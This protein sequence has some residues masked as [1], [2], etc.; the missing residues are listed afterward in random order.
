MLI[1]N[2]VLCALAV[3]TCAACTILFLRGYARTGRSL[4]LWSGLCFVFL[5]LNNVLLFLDLVVLEAD[6]RP[7]RHASAFAGLLF[8]VFGLLREQK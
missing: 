5:T 3:L 6:L 2:L 7:W 8:M 4:L 1:F